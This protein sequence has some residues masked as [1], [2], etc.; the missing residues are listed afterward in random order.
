MTAKKK[1]SKS[2]ELQA[3]IKARL[4]ALATLTDTARIGEEMQAYLK[5]Q[6]QF[7]RYS[8]RNTLLILMSNFDA[9]LVAGYRKWQQM[10]FQVCKG[11][12]GIPILAPQTYRGKAKKETAANTNDLVIGVESEAGKRQTRTGGIWFKTVYVFDVSQVGIPCYACQETNT[13]VVSVTDAETG[14][15]YEKEEDRRLPPVLAPHDAIHCPDCG[16]ELDVSL[17]QSPE[18]IT[19]GEDGAGLAARLETYAQS[20][21]IEVTEDDLHSAAGQSRIGKVVLDTGLSPL[22]RVRVLAHEIA[23]EL[24]HTREDRK[25]LSKAVKET[26]ADATAYAVCAHFGY[27]IPAPNY[28]AMWSDDSGL[29]LQRMDRIANATRR[30]IEAIETMEEHTIN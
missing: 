27:E 9:T 26:E 29:L 21:G 24:L 17:P 16:A 22:G 30:I 23:H 28:I 1:A 7:H 12:K 10:G 4:Q 25:T 3:T 11:E 15:V 13:V 2:A 14:E 20:V 18:W 8:F 6:G 5:F 19:E